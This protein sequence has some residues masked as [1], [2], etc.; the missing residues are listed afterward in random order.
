[1][2]KWP[3]LLMVRKLEQGGCERDAAKIA[4][5][6]DRSRFEPHMG[7]FVEGGIR[8]QE[9]LAAGVPIVH[10]P[11]RSLM[12]R[13]VTEGAKKLGG[14]VRRHGIQVVHAF[15]VP[16]DL[17]LA[18]AARF[19]RVP[20]IVTAQLS[21][22]DISPLAARILLRFTDWLSDAVVV[23]S[24][25]VA[26]SLERQL[27]FPK[28]KLYLCY[29]GV[30]SEHFH[31]GAGERPFLQEASLVVGS[32]CAMRPEKRVDWILRAFA[33]VRAS[34]P[35]AQLLL[36]G[37]GP[38]TTRLIDLSHQLGLRDC[39][40]FET[41]KAEVLPWMQSM[42]VFINSSSSESF[43]NALLEA[44]ACGC[45]PIGSRV[46]GIPELITHFEDGLTFDVNSLEQL[47]EMLSLAVTN[48]GLREKLRAQAV[49]TAHNR[50]S[51]ARTIQRM[52]SLYE[53]LLTRRGISKRS[54]EQ[55]ASVCQS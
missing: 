21:F 40:H 44:M 45:C 22:R 46:G 38:E 30:N 19:Y 55:N 2:K 51:I 48:A 3:V 34:H 26:R 24:Q 1:M 50:F 23:N 4:V 11:V 39:C 37:S 9:V 47:T 43:P 7:V 15:D 49:K 35:G 17:F 14:Y 33:R 6:L 53:N 28:R 31:P 8:T 32:V 54:P 18:P 42:D 10:L 36:V 27:R 5:G 12:N 25:A 41:A 16:T 52:E 13:S 29:N 20:A